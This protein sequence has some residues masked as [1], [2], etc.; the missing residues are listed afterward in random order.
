[1]NAMTQ[2]TVLTA[3]S[4]QW[5][6]RPA[7]ERF[8]SLTAMADHMNRVRD[9]SHAKTIS[10]RRLEARP[11]EEDRKGLVITGDLPG[12]QE[13][14]LPTHWSFGQLA[15]R[16]E[17]PAGYLRKLPNFLAADLINWGLRNRPVEEVA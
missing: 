4:R 9:R 12:G 6:T 2:P 10:V 3:A 13:L 16:A 17:A 5:A 15:A 11:V 1:M 14:A 7:D 8:T